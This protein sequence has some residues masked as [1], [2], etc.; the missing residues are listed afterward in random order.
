ME[1]TFQV[2]DE[3]ALF[4]EYRAALDAESEAN[5]AKSRAA[6]AVEEIEYRIRDLFE[7]TGRW[8][9][10]VSAKASGVTVSVVEK[11]RATYDPA[12]WP[13]V[14]RWAVQNDYTYIVQRRLNDKAIAELVM[15]PSAEEIAAEKKIRGEG[16]E[17][18]ATPLPDGLGIEYH[19]EIA[20]RRA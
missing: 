10:G 12:K 14:V 4:A 9:K 1:P 3:A 5:A 15:P 19:K 17:W 16:W 20:F 6:K 7:K 18:K 11:V 2:T 13:D 8:E